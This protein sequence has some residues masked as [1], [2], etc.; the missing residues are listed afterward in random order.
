[1]NIPLEPYKGTEHEFIDKKVSNGVDN[2]CK[3]C[4]YRYPQ[5]R[6]GLTLTSTSDFH[7]SEEYK[8]C[9]K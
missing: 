7:M 3:K 1:M 2:L 4:G 9:K 5:W 6:T 8:N